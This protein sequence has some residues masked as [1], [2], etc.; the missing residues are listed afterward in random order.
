MSDNKREYD[1]V[2]YGATGFT[3]RLVAD[4]LAA[5]DETFTW[6]IAGRNKAKL[7]AIK[8]EL[9]VDVGVIVADSADF[10][11][12]TRM[13]A[14]T[15]VLLTTVGPYVLYGEPL[16]KAC[17]ETATDYVDIT[18]EPEFVNNLITRL[19]EGARER[20]IRIVNCCGFDSIPHDFGVYYTVMQLPEAANVTIE[21]F[22]SA[23]GTFSG[24]TWASA[25]E[26]MGNLRKRSRSPQVPTVG[27]R[28]VK[29]IRGRIR[30]EPAVNGYAVPFPTIDPQI[31]LR[32]AKA[33]PA[34]GNQFRYGH[35]VRVGSAVTLAV[36]G[37]AMTGAVAMAQL[38]PTR[39]LLLKLRP[40]G[41]GPDAEK[42]ANSKFRVTFIGDADGEKIKTECSGGDPGYGETSKMISESALTLA[43]DRDKLPETYG[44]LTPVVA[45][46]DPLLERLIAAGIVFKTL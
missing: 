39:N 29:G 2:V 17:V 35:Y 36:G 27:N 16:V 30:R 4:Y 46:R 33:L 7:D 19:D 43:L 5:K 11:S 44:V 6:A 20:K 40:S 18:G 1:I 13:T 38:K 45:L 37:A 9:G 26:A 14:S 3:G 42:R 10:P 25:V 28:S 34:Y 23:S 24:G 12:L 32:S 22:V 31:V 41:E 15:R 21:G 8:A